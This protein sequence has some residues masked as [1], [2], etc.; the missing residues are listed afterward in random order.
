MEDKILHRI[1]YSLIGD[2]IKCSKAQGDSDSEKLEIYTD[3]LSNTRIYLQFQKKGDKNPE[4]LVVKYIIYEKKFS[5]IQ[6]KEIFSDS[7]EKEIRSHLEVLKLRLRVS[8][9]KLGQSHI[10]HPEYPQK[11]EINAIIPQARINCE[12]L[13]VGID[14]IERQTKKYLQN[15]PN[16]SL[17]NTLEYVERYNAI[18]QIKEPVLQ[19]ISFEALVEYI[20]NHLG[21]GKRKRSNNNGLFNSSSYKWSLATRDLVSHGVVLSNRTVQLLNARLA[22]SEIKFVFNRKEHLH[23][24][25]EAIQV[26]RQELY[27]YLS[28]L[29]L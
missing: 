7:A 9:L 13:I 4:K 15:Y 5:E 1:E 17:N 27:T 28:N 12:I 11:I 29:L 6:N 8:N 18:E 23:L 25:N 3:A 24:V 19:L 10:T 20:E 14:S 22:L 26:Y 21:I 16:Y 2:E